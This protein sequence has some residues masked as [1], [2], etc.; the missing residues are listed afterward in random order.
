MVTAVSELAI[1]EGTFT[2][3]LPSTEI[4]IVMMTDVKSTIFKGTF[5]NFGDRCWDGD[6]F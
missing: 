6:G 3:D 4:G 1:F 5:T 2:C